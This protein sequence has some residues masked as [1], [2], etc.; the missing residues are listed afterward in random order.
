MYKY[1]NLSRNQDINAIRVYPQTTIR[2]WRGWSIFLNL[3]AVYSMTFKPTFVLYRY[4][5]PCLWRF[6]LLVYKN[7]I[8]AS[9]NTTKNMMS[10][11]KNFIYFLFIVLN[12]LLS[13]RGHLTLPTK[14]LVACVLTFFA[15]FLHMNTLPKS[16]FWAAGIFVAILIHPHYKFLAFYVPIFNFFFRC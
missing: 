14:I 10:Y 1:E 2:Y 16:L 8:T 6:D 11:M 9:V 13:Q 4:K 12:V 5:I 15:Q 7:K 3:V